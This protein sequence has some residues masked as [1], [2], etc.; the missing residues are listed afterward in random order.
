MSVTVLMTNS[1]KYTYPDIFRAEVGIEE[2]V[3]N[4]EEPLD[5]VEVIQEREDGSKVE[6]GCEWIPQLYPIDKV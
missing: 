3:E 1:K 4:S 2:L 5:V 6:W